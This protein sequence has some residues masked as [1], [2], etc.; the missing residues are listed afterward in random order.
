MKKLLRQSDW[1]QYLFHLALAFSSFLLLG[2]TSS[3]AQL[4][5]VTSIN[6]SGPGS[7]RDAITT[8]TATAGAQ[9][10]I[11]NPA[12][13][14]PT[15]PCAAPFLDQSNVG[16]V[17]AGTAINSSEFAAQVITAGKSGILDSVDFAIR[18]FDGFTFG[19]ITLQIR[20]V[21]SGAPNSTILGSKTFANSSIAPATAE[22]TTFDLR[23]LNVFLKAGDVFSVV[24]FSTNQSGSLFPI[25]LTDNLYA[26]GNLF[27]STNGTN[28]VSF[29]TDTRFRTFVAETTPAPGTIT[30]ASQLPVITDPGDS[31]DG[32]GACVVLDG[33]NLPLEPVNGLNVSTGLRAR[34]SNVT[35]RGITFQNFLVND[36][37]IVEGRNGRTQVLG[38]MVTGNTFYRNF[39]G[40]RIQG[41]TENEDTNVEASIV[42]NLFDENQRGIRV[43]GNGGDIFTGS[44]G[45]NKVSA[46][47]DGNTIKA[48]QTEVVE[49]R[50]GIQII[51]AIARASKNHVTATV[52]NNNLTEVPDDGI[53]VIGCGGGAI[54]ELNKVDAVITGNVVRY[55]TNQFTSN[56]EFINSGIV[57]SGAA[58]ELNISE[59]KHNSIEFQV[60]NNNVEGFKNSNIVVN[61]GDEGTENN[62]VQGI[63]VGNTATNSPGN[64]G[65]TNLGGTGISVNAGSGTLHSVHDITITGNKVTGNKRRGISITGG[66]GTDSDVTRITV[67]SNHVD[68]TPPKL[69]KDVPPI[70]P[71]SDQDGIFVAGSNNALNTDLSEILIDGNIT[72]DNQRRGIFV[73]RSDEASNSVSLSGI[74]NNIS[75]GNVS[76]DGIFIA[77]NVPGSG[78]TPVAGN[79]CNDNGQDGLDINSPGYAL[80]N[81]SCSRN[82]GDGLNAVV[83]NTN[84]GGNSGRRNAA[85]NQP[86]FCFNTLLP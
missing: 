8:A 38:V 47:I 60:T 65:G 25:A 86:T 28:W 18:K 53:I 14:P 76:G 69:Q 45:G 67:S 58:G 64:P 71:A 54:G 24:V 48:A 26:G 83:G 16:V 21:N 77:S 32:S 9:T 33:K 5:T 44:D 11:F 59:C 34:A 13:F 35:I 43:A 72:K 31:I 40:V 10:I 70:E 46:F 52:S 81:N 23:S 78:G 29:G 2:A 55:K 85:C 12:V 4:I 84:D 51:G 50:D 22:F 66:S 7:L 42:G 15:T 49:D 57:V 20:R 36:A 17:T 1:A 41:T 30:L 73:T 37:V 27:S 63:I 82:V 61:G 3:W 74:T 75:T 80:S 6:D 68:G 39:R 56:P 79:Q 19:D 62:D